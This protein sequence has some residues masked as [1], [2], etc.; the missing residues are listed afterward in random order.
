M[1]G[2]QCSNYDSETAA[3]KLCNTPR[4]MTF[5][6]VHAQAVIHT[7][8]A[9]LTHRVPAYCGVQRSA[10][11]DWLMMVGKF[12]SNGFPATTKVNIKLPQKVALIPW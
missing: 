10:L 8:V 2:A 1:A 6:F 12:I 4:S 11:P 7:L 5:F 3:V 9:K